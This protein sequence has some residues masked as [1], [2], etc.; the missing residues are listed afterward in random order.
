MQIIKRDGR[1]NKKYN[2]SKIEKAVKSV[3]VATQTPVED[4]M[5]KEIAAAVE[6]NYLRVKKTLRSNIFKTWLNEN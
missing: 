5:V 4:E 2:V 3:R 1:K 6:E